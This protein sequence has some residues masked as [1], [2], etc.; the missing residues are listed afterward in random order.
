[1]ALLSHRRTV[2]VTLLFLLVVAG[3]FGANAVL[4]PGCSL[5]PVAVPD[6]ASDQ[7][8][9]VTSEQACAAL[10]QP[11]PR[12]AALPDGVRETWIS[13]D[14][15]GPAHVPRNV[16]VGYAKNGRG[17]G[18]L[19][20]MKGNTIPPGNT[21]EINSTVA[22]APAIVRQVHLASVNTNDMQYLWS[23]DGLLLSLH[24]QLVEG[25]TREAADAMAGSI[26]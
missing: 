23:R 1:M 7:S 6:D 20:V 15:G 2:M 10:G 3:T 17:V 25:I 24:V 8:Q 11:R 21:G 26:R 19:T 12:P 4:R 14:S 5:L 18:V 22:G 16:T 13:L 9:P